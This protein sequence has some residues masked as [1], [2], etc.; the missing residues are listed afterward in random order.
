MKSNKRKRRRRKRRRARD[1]KKR[2]AEHKNEAL[3]AWR[4]EIGTAGGPLT[5][6]R[7]RI[8]IDSLELAKGH[9]G[10][11]RGT[12][13]PVI[14]VGAYVVDADGA[15]VA[16]RALW[17]MERPTRFPCTVAPRGDGA[18]KRLRLTPPAALVVIAIAVEEDGGGDIQS[19]YAALEQVAAITVWPRHSDVP[20]PLHIDELARQMDTW[21]EWRSI[22]AMIDGAHVGDTLNDDDWIGAAALVTPCVPRFR[23]AQR[24]HFVSD[25]G[26]NDWTAELCVRM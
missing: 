26:L 23:G 8:D 22:H 14:I 9:D 13:E 12:P 2:K 16:G 11:L 21:R 20:A 6:C 10:F 3:V 25:D 7:V 24:L 19:L 4:G 15:R 5:K 18:D 17:H 1:R